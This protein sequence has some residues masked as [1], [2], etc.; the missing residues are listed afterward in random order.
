[1]AID[2]TRRIQNLQDRRFDRELQKSVLSESFRKSKLPSSVKYLI[3]TMIPIDKKYNDK[4]QEA[5]N[6][7][8]KHL[9]TNFDLHFERD[10]R[11]QGSVKTKTNIKVHSDFDLLAV[12]NRYHYNAS[13]V[14][15]MST[16]TASDP[17]EDIKELRKQSETILDNIYDI[18]DKEGTK[19]IAIFNKSLNRKVDVVFCYWY[20]TKEYIEQNNEFYRGIYLFDFVKE[21]KIKDFPFAH[22]KNVNYKGEQ[23]NDGSRK[24]IRLLKTMKV[25]SDSKIKLSSFHLTT[26][27]HDMSNDELYFD[28][29]GK[30]VL[31]A[32]AISNQLAKMI[33]NPV[34]R[35]GIKS[36]NGT[37]KPF[38]DDTIVEEL[39]KMKSELDSLLEDISR[40]LKSPI[41]RREIII[42]S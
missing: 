39:V 8:Q 10:Y 26:L 29:R 19:S 25:D 24:A 42:Y 23:T 34:Y 11:S 12:I 5:A 7:V 22:I 20:H 2:Y 30:E 41:N 18:V 40:E 15:T 1:M 16:Y 37:E 17:T 21:R 33:S 4:T 3:E 31:I 32:N 28:K 35:K 13:D 14:E 9:E 6:R 36:P 27:V 38:Q